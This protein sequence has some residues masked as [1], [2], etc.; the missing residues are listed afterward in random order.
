MDG[1][2]GDVDPAVRTEQRA[3][4]QEFKN[5]GNDKFNKSN[6]KGAIVDY[7]K[8]LLHE[9]N[10]P[11]LH[12]N[13]SAAYLHLEK[14]IEAEEHA[15]FSI[16][17][18]PNFYKGYMRAAKADHGKGMTRL[19]LKRLTQGLSNVTDP[20]GL[21]ELNRLKNSY[22]AYLSLQS[23]N[24][25][26]LEL[27][28]D[29]YQSEDD[30][31]EG[32]STDDDSGDDQSP[33]FD[34]PP[35]QAPTL[36]VE[37]LVSVGGSQQKPE[38][39]STESTAQSKGKPT[40][41]TAQ[42]KGKPTEPTALPKG[43]P[44]E[45]ITPSERKPTEPTIL[46]GK[47][48]TETTQL[49]GK[50]TDLSIKVE[51][52]TEPVEVKTS[53]D[54][55]KE[56]QKDAPYNSSEK[57]QELPLEF[58]RELARTSDM[59]KNIAEFKDN[60]KTGGQAY[61]SGNYR[62]AADNY[63]AAY[64]RVGKRYLDFETD[65]RQ[66]N[67]IRYASY[68][69]MINLNTYDEIVKGLNGLNEMT[70][71]GHDFP[72]IYIQIARAYYRLN[73]FKTALEPLEKVQ[74][75]IGN[76]PIFPTFIWPGTNNTIE[77]TTPNG[78]KNCIKELNLLCRMSH[79]PTAVCRFDNCLKT[80]S[81]ILP[82]ELIYT[83]DPDF[84]GYVKMMCEEKCHIEFHISCWKAFKETVCGIGK[85][86]DKDILGRRCLTTDCINS[87][88]EPS[89]ITTIEIIGA[90]GQVKC[91]NRHD[92]KAEQKAAD[93]KA[94]KKKSKLDDKD[95]KENKEKGTKPKKTKENK[96][97]TK[98]KKQPQ[99]VQE[100]TNME[101][102]DHE[103]QKHNTFVDPVKAMETRK[104]ALKELQK[105][106]FGQQE[107]TT[108]DPRYCFYGRSEES[109]KASNNQYLDQ[110]NDSIAV[111]DAKEFLFSY[112]ETFL[113]DEGPLKLTEVED[114][115]KEAAEGFFDIKVVLPELTSMC[116]L[117][118]E[119]TRFCQIE[120][121]LCLAEQL[122]E[123]YDTVKD[124]IVDTVTFLMTG[125]TNCETD[126]QQTDSIRDHEDG[127]SC[128][129]EETEC[130]SSSD[131]DDSEDEDSEEEDKDETEDMSQSPPAQNDV[132][133]TR[134][135]EY[136][137]QDAMK[138]LT[139]A[140]DY[141]MKNSE[142]EETSPTT[143]EIDSIKEQPEESISNETFE[144]AHGSSANTTAE[145]IKSSVLTDSPN[146]NDGCTE[147]FPS[148]S[149]ATVIPS[150]AEQ[151]IEVTSAV[152]QPQKS[153]VCVKPYYTFECDKGSQ[154]EVV[155]EERHIQTSPLE[156]K[157]RL[158]QTKESDLYKELNKENQ[159]LMSQLSAM[160][161]ENERLAKELASEKHV[162][163]VT[164]DAFS[165]LKKELDK[166]VEE[167]TKEKEKHKAELSKKDKE[168][169]KKEEELMKN[170]N[171][172]K[173][174]FDNV[175]R[176]NSQ[177]R[178]RVTTLLKDTVEVKKSLSTALINIKEREANY[179][180]LE[181]N[182]KNRLHKALQAQLTLIKTCWDTQLTLHKNRCR[183]KITEMQNWFSIAPGEVEKL[184]SY[185][186]I[187]QNIGQWVEVVTHLKQIEEVFQN[188]YS[189]IKEKI[190]QGND[191]DDLKP[192]ILPT[193]PK[194]PP[195]PPLEKIHKE[196][197]DK[198]LKTIADLTQLVASQQLQI[199]KSKEK[200]EQVHQVFMNAYGNTQMAASRM[201]QPITPAF[202]GLA[203]QYPYP[204]APQF[205]APTLPTATLPSVAQDP[206]QIGNSSKLPDV[207][208]LLQE[209]S[210]MF[211]SSSPVSSLLSPAM[212]DDARS[213]T[214]PHVGSYIF[215]PPMVPPI[216][217]T[218]P[219]AAASLSMPPPPIG[220]AQNLLKNSSTI[221][222]DQKKDT[223]ATEQRA[224]TPKLEQ[225]AGSSREST[226][227]PVSTPAAATPE[228]T[229]KK[230]KAKGTEAAAAEARIAAAVS[231]D[232][233]SAGGDEAAREDPNGWNV[234][235]PK[236]A[237]AKH[238][239]QPCGPLT[240][241]KMKNKRKLLEKLHSRFPTTPMRDLEDIVKQ[242][243][244]Q[245][246]GS[247]SGLPFDEIEARVERIVTKRQL[248][249][250]STM[251]LVK[252]SDAA[253]G[254][255]K[256]QENISWSNVHLE[257]CTICLEPMG[258]D[259]TK[260]DCNHEFHTKCLRKWLKEKSVCPLCNKFTT[261]P[262]EFPAL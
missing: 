78:L 250:T 116:D 247:L 214:P 245:N 161:K 189:E 58:I 196:T 121:R 62:K 59:K 10:N 127:A 125:A 236:S 213:Q 64:E 35:P 45:P 144:T 227:A 14:Y 232:S 238:A 60:L 104:E 139:K 204:G 44:T 100:D 243:R 105:D 165:R 190:K 75:I 191:M 230:K 231:L 5:S 203:L 174:G 179:K 168:F 219:L 57:K 46:S 109:I 221:L 9:P 170:Y 244:E 150:S 91:V 94:K 37:A 240:E 228:K 32:L 225:K 110:T 118:M 12:A 71:F 36:P 115:W 89:I 211:N 218:Q 43:K 217:P 248:Q 39:K 220:V 249:K 153:H 173:A 145:D 28:S 31:D 138:E 158:S 162:Q 30:E 47:E 8:G 233:A 222:T 239:P 55:E 180:A 141:L 171:M 2:L 122:E 63:K 172:T 209:S 95:N 178:D 72:A 88:G 119:S 237:M 76:C 130:E 111:K 123:V 167:Q 93:K 66:C 117:L 234:V 226:P 216:L 26:E 42:S 129:G 177:L 124:E 107:K 151:S 67:V 169:K 6:Y 4:A 11:D 160:S 254:T 183:E 175:A 73:R 3:K 99:T 49:E 224:G 201:Q 24:E 120:D 163:K 97:K 155:T 19:A 40:E 199:Q 181:L 131:S 187:H 260:V 17:L 113:K 85:I 223:K 200:A 241:S 164:Q 143:S 16:H 13:L 86:N 51:L 68:T 23:N 83:T 7:Q 148:D 156:T 135:L 80:S 147:A 81:H 253:W 252:F 18:R 27:D 259:R 256:P 70:K 126:S 41:P 197:T 206:A 77:E 188:Q 33:P 159:K 262:D 53:T 251:G 194:E 20:N 69:A 154:S 29:T 202:G 128:S 21:K 34:E 50:P 103:L 87:E 207:H 137:L 176:E 258:H 157:D 185:P 246:N 102:E 22:T 112:F 140:T 198:H 184:P 90:D 261:M 38:E 193:M 84:I 152:E 114:Q 142:K 132:P 98:E 82:S 52:K 108:W 54:L 1:Q 242:V 257:E 192:D 166:T 48:S 101:E 205:S 210:K 208:T 149:E 136:S 92:P 134:S 195:L 235:L 106:K 186:E 65:E 255:V 79:K 146:S 61:L 229:K 212:K 182:M 96:I 215:P 74:E 133:I 56:S 25:K 15:L